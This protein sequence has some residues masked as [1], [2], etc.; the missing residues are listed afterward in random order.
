MPVTNIAPVNAATNTAKNPDKFSTPILTLPP[1]S[2]ITTATPS[3]APLVIPK[4]EGPANGLRNAVCNINPLTDKAT[5]H[6]IA[7]TACGNRDSRMMYRQL[8][9]T[10]FSPVRTVQTSAGGIRIGP[11]MRLSVKRTAMRMG[12]IINKILPRL[13]PEGR[14]SK[15]LLYIILFL[16]IFHF[17]IFNSQ[18]PIFSGRNS[19]ESF[20]IFAEK[21]ICREI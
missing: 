15:G 14:N 12:R 18:F 5:P 7:V 8:S 11:T 1:N 19:C 9:F 4:T 2:S 20:E 10:P 17:S 21:A 13:F 6:R 16:S 3:P